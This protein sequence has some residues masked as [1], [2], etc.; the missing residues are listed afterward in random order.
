[1]KVFALFNVKGGVGKTAGAVN[2]AW[3]SAREGARTLLVDLDPQGAA[4]FTFRIETRIE[5]GVERLLC[6][7]GVVSA[8]IRG[9]DVERLDVLPSD[10]SFHDLGTELAQDPGRLHALL[11]PLE[12]EYDRVF[13]DCAPGLSPVAEAVFDAA[14]A[15][16][17]P[18]IPTT[19]SL[20]TL[21]QLTKHLKRHAQPPPALPY[22]GLVDRRKALHRSAL[23]WAEERALGFLRTAI[24][25]SAVVEQMSQLR[26]PLFLHAPASP[27]A[28][29]YVEP[30]RE[31][32]E[33]L[34]A[35]TERSLEC[36]KEARETI[37]RWIQPVRPPA[38]RAEIPDTAPGE[39]ERGLA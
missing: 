5:G 39:L 13:L 25:Y 1:M 37:E 12:R 19:L 28:L 29:A 24:P 22:F 23:A 20:R 3:L 36:S 14:D 11:A 10:P 33:L 27:A 26:G 34:A 31:I 9:S 2:L 15:L 18:T 7:P 6:D 17:V 35:G 21:A 8:A 16:L 32:Q 30:W 38:A 4:T